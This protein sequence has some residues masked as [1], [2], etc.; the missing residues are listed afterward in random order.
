[1][2]R[3]QAS[4]TKVAILQ[5][6]N[7]HLLVFGLGCI[8]G[9]TGATL[10]DLGEGYSTTS[11]TVSF[12]I[13]TR[14]LGSILLCLL[15]GTVF[16]FF[17]MQQVMILSLIVLAI[18]E[19]ATPLLGSLTACHICTFLV[20]GGIGLVEAGL[21]F[22]IFAIWKEKSGPIFQLLNFCS[23][24]GGVASPLLAAP[25]LKAVEIPV[26]VS[27]AE[28]PETG[29]PLPAE[30]TRVFIPYL[31]VGGVFAVAAILFI[32]SFVMDRS[33]IGVSD[34]EANDSCCSR[35]LQQ[36]MIANFCFYALANVS[37]EQTYVSM[38][39]LFVVQHLGFS[40]SNSVY[41]SAVFWTFFT[42]S[43]VV[44]T[45]ASFK[46]SPHSMLVV[47][48]A[49]VL[50]PAGA[51]CLFVESATEVIWI[52]T[53]VLGFGA[54]PLFP[55]SFTHLQ[56]YVH[57]SQS[58]S[59][60]IMMCVCIGAMLPPVLVGPF[61]DDRPIAFVYVIFALAVLSATAFVTS[62]ILKQGKGMRPSMMRK[63]SP[64]GVAE[65]TSSDT[66]TKSVRL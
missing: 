47:S 10:I 5:T 36:L 48:H 44:A 13:T 60:M 24:F 22:W 18:G 59:A 49:L 2:R 46:M 57:L 64:S 25:F 65:E 38:L 56:Q 23:G 15:A 39:A 62:L 50:L 4:P 55:S 66:K 8:Y 26:N 12:I 3:S 27:M 20:G 28:P 52:C 61:I 21:N 30:V 35:R 40:K 6:V 9:M 54:S 14:G 32:A 58:H 63:Q 41:L 11:T 17:N 42:A 37:L 43:R 45:I 1:M 19:G 53:A 33:N 31:M 34:A 7:L 51:M 16:R 29:I